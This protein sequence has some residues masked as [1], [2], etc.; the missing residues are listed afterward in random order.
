M[1]DAM[2]YVMDD[3]SAFRWM[4]YAELAD[5]RGISTASAIRLTF[6]KKWR[7]QAGNDGIARVAVPNGEETPRR[8]AK[9]DDTHADTPDTIPDISHALKVL[10]LAVSTLRERAEAAE[11]RSDHAEDRADKLQA[12]NV[13]LREE[14]DKWRVQAEMLIRRA[15]WRRWRR[16]RVP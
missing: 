7:R 11:K 9:D 3:E 12:E 6:R 13:E 2:G 15:W 5:A 14:R 1:D 16:S 8:E 10:E 4:T